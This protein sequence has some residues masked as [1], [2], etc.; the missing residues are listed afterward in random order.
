M[1]QV[2]RTVALLSLA[3]LVVFDYDVTMLPL[4]DVINYEMAL[5]M[6]CCSWLS[7]SPGGVKLPFLSYVIEGNLNI[8]YF[9]FMRN[10]VTRLED[11]ILARQRFIKIKTSL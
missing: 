3:A 4:R 7:L 1:G 6:V 11:F 2:G 10:Y 5:A 9:H 8:F